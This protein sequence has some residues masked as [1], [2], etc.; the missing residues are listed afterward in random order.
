MHNALLAAAIVS[1]LYATTVTAAAPSTCEYIRGEPMPL[2][3]Q[4][5]YSRPVLEGKINS[6]TVPMLVD[7][8]AAYTLIKARSIELLQLPARLQRGGA[9]GLGGL[10]RRS[11]T[12][13]VSEFSVGN[14]KPIRANFPVAAMSQHDV[15]GAV[16]GVDFLLQADLEIDFAAHRLQFNRLGNCSKDTVLL[17]NAAVLDAPV[18][19]S[20]PRP[21]FYVNVNA[22][23]VRTLI[24]TG[25][26]Y[27][28]IDIHAARRAGITPSMPGAMERTPVT[29]AG[30]GS[31]AAWIVPVSEMGIGKD[32]H[33][34]LKIT[35]TT[36]N[37]NTADPRGTEMILGTDF[38]AS[39]RVL[40]SRSQGKVYL[41]NKAPL[42]LITSIADRVEWLEINAAQ[43]NPGAMAHLAMRLENGEGIAQDTARAAKLRETAG[44]KG[45]FKTRLQKANQQ[46]S[47]G[48]FAIAAPALRQLAQSVSSSRYTELEAYIATALNGETHTAQEELKIFLK[49]ANDES[50]PTPIMEFLAGESSASSLLKTARKDEG[51]ANSRECEAHYYIAQA[52]R[53]KGDRGAARQ[54]FESALAICPASGFEHRASTTALKQTEL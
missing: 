18:D 19:A 35:L 48:E 32:T 13:A 46:L 20:D 9:A 27:S 49:R 31:L 8:G 45:D 2:Q 53:L 36:V 29:G 42:K 10:T 54:S 41:E 51:R 17:P 52:A 4:G 43:G 25:A 44:A 39:H 50:W 23:P 40:F 30:E 34:N 14:T 15:F 16:L 1:T 38:L 7:T 21:H 5:W 3:I 47:D 11:F 33:K 6:L 24:D 28:L 37:H 12:T 26:P 22:V